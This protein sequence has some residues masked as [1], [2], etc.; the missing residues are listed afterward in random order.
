VRELSKDD[1]YALARSVL[2]FQFFDVH[3]VTSTSFS[4]GLWSFIIEESVYGFWSRGEF[5]NTKK[6]RRP[7]AQ[8][9]RALAMCGCGFATPHRAVFG[10]VI[11]D[12][13][14][15]AGPFGGL[16]HGERCDHQLGLNTVKL[17]VRPR[18]SARNGSAGALR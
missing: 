5:Y 2:L 15:D 6:A 8:I 18:T 12:K 1:A 17:M 4:T 3:V 14:Y 10:A 13:P 7:T 16:H 11:T 9:K